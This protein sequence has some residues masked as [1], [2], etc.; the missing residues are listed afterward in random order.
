MAYISSGRHKFSGR[1]YENGEVV[2][3]EIITG[4]LV[5]MKLVTPIPDQLVGGILDGWDPSDHTVAEVR[6]FVTK[7]PT[8]L[9]RVLAD[10]RVG[11]Q[12]VTLLEWLEDRAAE[13]DASAGGED[14][15]GNPLTPGD[16]QGYDPSGE[17]VDE[18]LAYV[19]ANPDSRDAVR[20]AE[21]AGK[22]RKTLVEAL[23]SDGE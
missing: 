4:H 16:P 5:Q 19:A 2:P 17:T 22:N 3:D 6:D 18:V 1:W 8:Q 14:P 10:E 15:G 13:E 7:H 20:A 12:R 21:V 23:D 9:E 11:E